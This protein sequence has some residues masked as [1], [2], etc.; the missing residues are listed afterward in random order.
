MN[1]HRSRAINQQPCNSCSCLRRLSREAWALSYLPP[2]PLKLSSGP[3]RLFQNIHDGSISCY[4][5]SL[6]VMIGEYH[7]NI[8]S[9]DFS[10]GAG[11]KEPT[12]QCRR[13]KRCGF[14]PWV[15]K[16]PGGGHGNRLQYSCLENPLDKGAW[17]VIVRR[18]SKSRT[19]M[20]QL[21]AD[22]LCFSK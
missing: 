12:C 18:V 5:W 13:H 22:P 9:L 16:I 20:K 17:R 8:T 19:Q 4:I 10:G 2:V 7:H 14:D 1:M 11:S 3:Q 21:S 6:V 15:K